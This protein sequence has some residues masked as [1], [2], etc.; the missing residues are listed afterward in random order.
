MAYSGCISPSTSL[1]IS[2]ALLY[3][4]SAWDVVPLRFVQTS[5]IIQAQG[6]PGMFSPQAL[7][8]GFQRRS[9]TKPP[10]WHSSLA[11]CTLQ[12]GYSDSWQNRYVSPPTTSLLNFQGLLKQRGCL[13]KVPLHVVHNQPGYSDLRHNQ[14]VSPP[15]LLL[16]ICR[17]FSNKGS[18]LP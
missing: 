14:G 1:L 7:P 11:I 12:P 15:T 6:I 18:A 9:D 2:M 5:K 17:A 4:A 16:R 13:D 3:K 10:P 8:C